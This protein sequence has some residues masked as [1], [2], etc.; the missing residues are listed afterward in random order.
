MG[1]PKI[2]ILSRDTIAEAALGLIDRDGKVTVSGVAKALGVSPPSLYNHV[3]GLDEIVELVRDRIHVQQGPK[4]DPSWTW[5]QVVRHVAQHDRDSIGQ[6]PW[7]VAD[8][9][10]STVKADA[11]LESVR[12]FARVLEDAGFEPD[13]VLAIIGS[14]DLLTAG[15]ALDLNAPER[16]YPMDAELVDDP[17]ARALRAAPKGRA[18]ADFVFAFA[19]DALVAA[20]EQRIGR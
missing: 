8:L 10:I 13:D 20:L 7:T 4:I 2:A 15:G 5:Q 9:M 6:H 18:R 17:L 19:V 3:S 11:P 16:V 1:R 12:T 14:V